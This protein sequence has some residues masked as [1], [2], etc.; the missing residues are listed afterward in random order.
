MIA[1]QI[2]VPSLKSVPSLKTAP[3]PGIGRDDRPVHARA[4]PIAVRD[5]QE[6]FVTRRPAPE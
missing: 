6:P 1:V 4:A 2:R 3:P 5:T